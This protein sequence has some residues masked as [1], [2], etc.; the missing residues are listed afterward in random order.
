VLGQTI[1]RLGAAFI[2]AALLD[3]AIP[4]NSGLEELAHRESGLAVDVIKGH[5]K[6]EPHLTTVAAW[7]NIHGEVSGKKTS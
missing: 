1:K 3:N 5:G 2:R 6:V 4:L 7:T